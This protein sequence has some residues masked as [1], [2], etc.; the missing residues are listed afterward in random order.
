[1]AQAPP[2]ALHPACASIDLLPCLQSFSVVLLFRAPLGVLAPPSSC[3]ECLP[4]LASR[5][6]PDFVVAT[7]ISK[8]E[9]ELMDLKAVSLAMVGACSVE[10]LTDLEAVRLAMD[11]CMVFL[12]ILHLGTVM[13]IL[14]SSQMNIQKSKTMA[15]IKYQSVLLNRWTREGCMRKLDPKPR[16]KNFAEVVRPISVI[17]T[18]GAA[19]STFWC[20]TCWFR[21]H[22]HLCAITFSSENDCLAF[23]NVRPL[24][25]TAIN[26]FVRKI[27]ILVTV[28]EGFP[29]GIGAEICVAVVWWLQ[30]VNTSKGAIFEDVLESLKKKT[31]RWT[32]SSMLMS[33]SILLTD[34]F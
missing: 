2:T 20:F 4:W 25:R 19:S 11:S 32:S 23:G 33:S 7:E 16:L 3:C 15:R 6:V 24:D 27:N 17:E 18:N 13:R 14:Q 21:L 10:D 12:T 22:S 26:A 1:M 5:R 30:M 9:A 34:G 28:E 8:N 31:Q 29:H